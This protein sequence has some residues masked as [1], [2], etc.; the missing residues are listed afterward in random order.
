M[1]AIYFLLKNPK[2]RLNRFIALLSFML[3]FYQLNEFF[4]CVLKLNM[5]TRMAFATTAVLPA[6][7]VSYALLMWR[8]HLGLYWRMLI[9]SPAAFFVIMF[10]LPITF[11]QS[12]T[13]DTVFIQYPNNGLITQFF[14]LYYIVYMVGAAVLFY[15]SATTAKSE[16]EKRLY[17]LGMLGMFV[18]TVP[19][20][21]FLIFLPQ[22]K[23][24]FASVL[25]EFAL[26]LAIEF[27]IV[28]WYKEKHKIKY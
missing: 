9:Y 26:L 15:F 2:D 22:F 27:V 14:S 8:K 5:F 7:G 24:Q 19:T 28:L 18:F 3:G 12:A 20:Y 4:I 11:R 13:C 21:I 16:P 1:L 25:C 17:Y 10:A 6:M 23:V